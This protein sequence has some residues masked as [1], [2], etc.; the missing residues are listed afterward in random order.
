MT[1]TLFLDLSLAKQNY[2]LCMGNSRSFFTRQFQ[3]FGSSKIF[4]YP[5]TW[6]VMDEQDIQLEGSICSACACRTLSRNGGL[7]SAVL[8][9]AKGLGT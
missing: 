5:L 6:R 9:P 2:F 4:L 7:G 1:L 8:L 3:G